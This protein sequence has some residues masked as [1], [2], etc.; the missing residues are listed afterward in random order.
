MARSTRT[1]GA[2]AVLLAQFLP[3]L[4]LLGRE[5][6][7]HLDVH[8]RAEGLAFF[9]LLLVGE[10]GVFVEGSAL[11][12]LIFHG[13]LKFRLLIIRELQFLGEP[14]THAGAATARAGFAF[15]FAGCVGVFGTKCW[16]A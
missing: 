7:L 5:D 6:G 15:V 4:K 2:G 1:T 8:F 13:C 10:A 14:F 16:A 9:A 3:F 11:L 12:A